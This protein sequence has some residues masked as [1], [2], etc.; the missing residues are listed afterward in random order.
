MID[1]YKKLAFIFN[2]VNKLLAAI[3][4]LRRFG[5]GAG[6][7]LQMNYNGAGNKERF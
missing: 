3:N 6:C 1:N 2:M 4:I 7:I 5:G